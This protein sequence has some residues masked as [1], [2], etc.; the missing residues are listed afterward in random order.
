M[1]EERAWGD[2]IGARVRPAFAAGLAAL[3]DFLLPAQCA[4]CH[5][6]VQAH[7][8]LCAG[9]WRGLGFIEQPFCERLGIPFAIDPGVPTLSLRA[10]VE[11]PDYDHARAAVLFNDI[12]RALIH[13]LKYRDRHDVA[14]MMARLMARAGGELLA[15]ASIIAP[16]PLHRARQWRRRF[17]QSAL[18]ARLIARQTGLAAEPGLMQRTR[19]TRQQVGLSADQRRRNVAGAFAVSPAHAGRVSGAHIVLI[20]DVLTT[21][22]TAEGCARALRR[23]GARR[24]DVLVFARV[25]DVIQSPI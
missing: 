23:A 3:A 4:V 20:D 2:G 10:Q 16:V 19:P 7:G 24:I 12:S 21:G 8:H 1:N 18:L 5:T 13:G 15:D 11:P 17:N 14:L 22:A 6:P 25:A 9:C